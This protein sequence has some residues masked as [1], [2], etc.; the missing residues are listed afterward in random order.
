VDVVIVEI[1]GTVASIEACRFLGKRSAKC[2]KV[3]PQQQLVFYIHDTC[4]PSAQPAG[5][6]AH[7]ALGDGLRRV[8]ITP[9][10]LIYRLKLDVPDVR[11]EKIALF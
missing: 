9:D 3:E 7:T 11:A 2:A 10:A 1:G 8:G 6:P 5:K 4:P